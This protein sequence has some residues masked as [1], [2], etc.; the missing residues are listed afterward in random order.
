[1]TVAS[2]TATGNNL[3][4]ALWIEDSYN[5]TASDIWYVAEVDFVQSDSVSDSVDLLSSESEFIRCQ[6]FF[7][8][9]YEPDVEPGAVDL[10]GSLFF[11]TPIAVDLSDTLMPVRFP[12]LMRTQPSITL[13]AGDTGT[14]GKLY[15]ENSAADRTAS[16]SQIST[17]GF[18]WLHN[19]ATGSSAG[20]R[21]NGHYA[22]DAR[23]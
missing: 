3:G 17:N 5:S 21:L 15:N 16:A 20:D 10:N 6:R 18:H 8:K 2:L 13:Y 22:S 14:S 4:I 11:I 23:L 12:V 1:M 7:Q 9:S 19:D